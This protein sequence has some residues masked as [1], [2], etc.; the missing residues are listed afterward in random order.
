M[1]QLTLPLLG[2]LLL[3]GPAAADDWTQWQGPDRNNV[4]KETGLLKTWPKGG[5]K[6]LWTFSEA[7]MGYTAPAVV[8]DRLYTM[9]GTGGKDYLFALEAKTGKKVWA[10]PLGP[11]F[12]QNRGDGPRGTPTVD[13]DRLYLITGSGNLICLQT[14]DGKEVWRKGLRT[15]LGGNMQSGWGY[16]ESPLVDGDQVV[17]T[18]GGRLGA[19]AALDKKTGAVTWRS[20]DFTDKAA[21]SSLVV[22]N[23]GGERQYV[24]MTGESVAGVAA[25]DGKLLWRF[26]RPSR[27]AAIP[28]PVVFGD[29]V[30]V[31][32]GYGTGCALLKVRK[33]GDKFQADQVYANRNM[34]NHHGGVVLLDGHVYGYGDGKGWA[35][36]NVLKGDLAWQDNRKLAKGSVAYADGHL[37]CYSERDGTLVLVPATTAGWK[38]DGRMSLPRKSTLERP[39]AQ[40][41]NNVWTHPVVANGR[42]YLRDQDLIFCFDVKAQ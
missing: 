40:S 12:E 29:H 31:S 30:Y 14:A 35:C 3:A 11:M 36:Q 37:Y 41:S 38:E 42:L 8:G 39:S 16:S 25:K 19:V 6:L 20:K 34:T 17:C 23:F 28:T 26:A 33:D 5:P 21:Y 15:D 18:P 27:I 7:G 24:Q 10:A 22:A 2:G 9:G 1:K 32:S 13:G 4:S